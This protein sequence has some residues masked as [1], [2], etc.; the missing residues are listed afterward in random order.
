MHTKV[1]EKKTYVIRNNND[2]PRAVVLE[3]PV[4]AEWKLVETPP[5]AESSSSYHRFKVEAKPKTTTEFA[6]RE[7]NP[8]QT[9]Y[10]IANVTPELIALWVRE[11]TIDP[12]IE[13]ALGRI[14]AKKN[15]INQLNQK[16]AALENQQNEI[17]RDQERVRENLRRMGNTP[18]EANLRL[19]YIRQLE[20]QENRLGAM[21]AERNRLEDAR[22]A[23][24]KQLDEMLQNLSFDR[25]L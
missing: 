21:R 24:Q 18:E 22:A 3:H 11:R 16:I 15:E 2:M 12:E 10:A 7:E 25:K 9:T 13:Q 19:R 4:R 6:V 20:Q 5:A 8:Q 17:F 1:V 14:V 23:A